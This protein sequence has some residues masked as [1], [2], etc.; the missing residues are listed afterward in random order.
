MRTAALALVATILSVPVVSARAA[1][2][3]QQPQKGTPGPAEKAG[4]ALDQAGRDVKEGAKEAAREVS[5]AFRDA[6]DKLRT[7]RQD[8][9][10]DQLRDARDRWGALLNKPMVRDELRLHARRMARL[11]YIETLAGDVNMDPIQERARRARDLEKERFDR[12]MAAL[13][14]SGGEK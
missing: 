7:T 6:R 1:A 14:A 5:K 8:R 4:K 13:R 3:Q 11:N 2:Q 12:R 9:R 10:R